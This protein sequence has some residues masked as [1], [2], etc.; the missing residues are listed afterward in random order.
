MSRLHE[1]SVIATA[2]RG[3]GDQGPEAITALAALN[4]M[5]Q[6]LDVR[7]DA[8][9]G[10]KRPK[11]GT[12][13]E[14]KP[15]PGMSLTRTLYGNVSVNYY[16]FGRGSTRALEPDA[17][18]QANSLA[19]GFSD[20]SDGG[21]GATPALVLR[22]YAHYITRG[23]QPHYDEVLLTE[24]DGDFSI[25]SVPGD[26]ELIRVVSAGRVAPDGYVNVG[27]L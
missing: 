13:F 4:R 20:F 18:F 3:L 12:V 24:N 19:L 15:A 5:L 25:E 1:D 8:K 2:E 17:P 22:A 9:T 27:R 23:Y 16:Q 6:G 26:A 14:V 11:V 10:A 7:N 21:R